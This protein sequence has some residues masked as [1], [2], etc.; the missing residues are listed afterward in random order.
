MADQVARQ[1]SSNKILEILFSAVALVPINVFADTPGFS[2]ETTPAPGNPPGVSP[3]PS[4]KGSG[5]ETTSSSTGIPVQIA[6]QVP[7]NRDVAFILE[8][9][10]DAGFGQRV[11]QT[12]VRGTG[13]LWIAPQ[14]GVY[15]WRLSK[16]DKKMFGGEVMSTV[17]GSFVAID[18]EVSR[19]KPAKVSWA[20]VK[21]ADQYKI[22]MF[23][24]QGRTRISTTQSTFVLIPQ[25]APSSGG[26]TMVEVIPQKG[27]VS[28]QRSYHF[29]PSLY[30]SSGR[31]ETPPPPPAPVTQTTP[32]KPLAAQGASDKMPAPTESQGASLPPLNPVPPRERLLHTVGLNGLYVSENLRLDKLDLSLENDFKTGGGAL[33]VWASPIPG[34]VVSLDADVWKLQGEI[35]RTTTQVTNGGLNLAPEVVS[36]RFLVHAG[37]GFDFLSFW[38][39][40][41]GSLS[42]SVIG[43]SSSVPLLPKT[44][45]I[46]TRSTPFPTDPK[47]K[48]EVQT[49]GGGKL[50]FYWG[51]TYAGMWLD[52]FHL[53]DGD[54]NHKISGGSLIAEYYPTPSLAIQAGVL[55]QK[56]QWIICEADPAQCLAEGKVATSSR[57]VAGL[58]GAA[59]VLK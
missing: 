34:F 31:P 49:L 15:H 25:T 13:H 44:Y 26:V 36:T 11:F 42:L 53:V 59:L 41:E 30:F 3:G 18:P 55:G 46:P 19:P 9:A 40:N 54:S 7:L 28:L 58:L 20:G 21:G 33:K 50:A 35:P 8:V 10:R 32:D 2:Q 47:I 24:Q 39:I 48:D 17:S 1:G 22:F 12:Q 52:A 5:D 27:A 56:G 16:A 14:E 6:W 45:D 23:D 37:L 4:Q 51:G 29:L 57:V 38:D 43:G